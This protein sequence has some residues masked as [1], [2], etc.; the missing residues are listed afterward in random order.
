MGDSGRQPIPSQ[1][2]AGRLPDRT[3]LGM[4]SV[5]EL[6]QPAASIPAKALPGAP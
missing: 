6:V 4:G 5:V 2:C 1:L 3:F